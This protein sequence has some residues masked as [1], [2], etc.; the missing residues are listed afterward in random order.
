MTNIQEEYKK[1]LDNL[2]DRELENMIDI[3]FNL[4]EKIK[5]DQLL[6]YIYK[7]VYHR[8][9]MRNLHIQIEAELNKY[10]IKVV[11]S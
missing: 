10:F 2:H 7:L 1:Y 11:I 8:D 5:N 4:N 3:L 6:S 9:S